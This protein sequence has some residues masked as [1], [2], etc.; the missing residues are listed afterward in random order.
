MLKVSMGLVGGQKWKKEKTLDGSALGYAFYAW[1][2]LWW[3]FETRKSEKNGYG[4]DIHLG[5]VLAQLFDEYGQ[6]Y[7]S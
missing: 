6:G 3:P 2:K 7:N 1:W 4:N 5:H